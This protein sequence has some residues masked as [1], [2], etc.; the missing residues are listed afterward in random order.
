MD[1]EEELTELRSKVSDMRMILV[2]VYNFLRR[3]AP[4]SDIYHKVREA[5]GY[6][7]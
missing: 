2:D 6:R 1:P 3:I 5:L 4:N 7:E